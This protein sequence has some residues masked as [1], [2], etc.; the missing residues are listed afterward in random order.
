MRSDS[1]SA[2]GN[3]QK[4]NITHELEPGVAMSRSHQTGSRADTWASNLGRAGHLGA[5]TYQ[6]CMHDLS[7]CISGP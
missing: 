7:G 2:T 6:P 5:G 3:Y 1:Y 4:H